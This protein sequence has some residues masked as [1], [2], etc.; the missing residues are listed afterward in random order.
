MLDKRKRGLYNTTCTPH[1]EV[2]KWLKVSDLKSDRSRKR[3]EGSNPSFSAFPLSGTAA[4][5]NIFILTLE[6]YPSWPKGHP[7]KGCRSLIAAR[8]FKSLLLREKREPE[9]LSF[10]AEKAVGYCP[11]APEARLRR[12]AD[13][14]VRRRD[15][16][17]GTIQRAAKPR[18]GR[19]RL[20]CEPSL[21]LRDEEM[22]NS[23]IFQRIP[24]C[25]S[26]ERM[27]LP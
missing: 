6:K 4:Q 15:A 14:A 1:G 23:L 27:H 25:N 12:P 11:R 21:L 22:R 2:T 5:L 24:R 19:V 13:R 7:W 8:G 26:K 18:V 20:A 10:F 16:A 17:A 9:R 3:R